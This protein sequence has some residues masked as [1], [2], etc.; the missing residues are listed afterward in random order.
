MNAVLRKTIEHWSHLQPYMHVP[1]NE[2][3]YEEMLALVEKLMEALRSAKK[4]EN[5]ASLLRLVTRNIE[6]YE[7]RR[8]PAKHMTPIDMLEFLIEEYG[9][10]QGDLPEIGSQSLVSK[11]LSGERQ[12]T[13][14]HIQRL[15][16][17]FGVSSSVFIEGSR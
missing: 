15:S 2:S 8:Y 16:K 14:E 3:E 10:S 13:V 5:L 17:R 6:E 7:T 9:L 12:L 1:R 11:V 4:N